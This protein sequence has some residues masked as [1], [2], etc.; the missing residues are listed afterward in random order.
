MS[1][2]QESEYRQGGEDEQGTQVYE[3][4]K[5]QVVFLIDVSEPNFRAFY[6]VEDPE[7]GETKSYSPFDYAMVTLR[8]HL[9]ARILNNPDDETAVL[10][11]GAAR[12]ENRGRLDNVYEFLDLDAGSAKRVLKAD[13]FQAADFHDIIGSLISQDGVPHSESLRFGLWA[14]GQ[15]LTTKA[16]ALKRVFLFTNCENPAGLS[17]RRQ[18]YKTNVI[19]R[20]KELRNANISVVVFPLAAGGVSFDMRIF[21]DDFIV[22]V[23]EEGDSPD[24]YEYMK[25]EFTAEDTEARLG[26]LEEMIRKKT[27]KRRTASRL[28]WRLTPQSWDLDGEDAA[29]AAAATGCPR[30]GLEIGLQVY[31]LIQPAIAPSKV[32]IHAQSNDLL[33][34]ERRV[35]DATTGAMLS[36]DAKMKEF[37]L[38]S[39]DKDRFPKVGFS[40]FL[41]P[42]DSDISGSST[43]FKAILDAMIRQDKIAICRAQIGHAGTASLAAVLPQIEVRDQFQVQLQPEGMHI[44]KLPFMDDLRYP[45]TDFK[46][47]GNKAVVASEAAIE[48]AS[49]LM[50][51]IT[52]K[53]DHEGKV[54]F[55]TEDVPNPSMQRIAQVIEAVALGSKTPPIEEFN[56]ATAPDVKV[57]EGL[58][59]TQLQKFVDEVF[60][61]AGCTA[62]A[63]VPKSAGATKRKAPD[64]CTEQ[65]YHAYEWSALI[66]KP[67]ELKRLVVIDLKVYLSFH[68][69]KVTGK[70]DELV[71]RII[72]HAAQSMTGNASFF[73]V[74]SQQL[75]GTN[76]LHKRPVGSGATAQALGLVRLEPAEGELGFSPNRG[77][78]SNL[79]LF[80]Q[81]CASKVL[82]GVLMDSKRQNEPNRGSSKDERSAGQM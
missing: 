48:K 17:D 33:R 70:K 39:G 42:N 60:G 28:R 1:E 79:S 2:Y 24:E 36:D 11:F 54:E 6:E 30:N 14:A 50:D 46:V 45:G 21:W 61:S 26:S 58:Y 35:V 4:S 62:A 47:A 27:H 37:V 5:E 34:T 65:I 73:D 55:N 31:N 49:A 51:A 29:A 68:G 59:H 20:A 22:A 75:P 12:T 80:L 18:Y 52:F 76:E 74:W 23:K 3:E 66:G 78:R 32:K 15:V 81:N 43:V 10:F 8:Q 72:E 44:I 82:R 56:D 9:R 57:M 71:E 41:R 69:L 13:N 7:T 19:A 77:D 64:A 63:A 38:P 40:Y 16:K 53:K 67:D 25:G